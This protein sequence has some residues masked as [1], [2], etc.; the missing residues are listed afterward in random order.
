MQTPK[1]SQP[2]AKGRGHA[3]VLRASVLIGVVNAA[4]RQL[5][6]LSLVS[7]SARPMLKKQF[8][9][10]VKTV[11]NAYKSQGS[12][13]DFRDLV[14]ESLGGHFDLFQ[15]LRRACG[16]PCRKR[17]QLIIPPTVGLPSSSSRAS[18]G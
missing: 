6:C 10:D 7:T 13:D 5:G 12:V 16:L 17:H 2:L 15:K 11:F 3:N 8:D 18:S 1:S 9:E 4:D 14:N